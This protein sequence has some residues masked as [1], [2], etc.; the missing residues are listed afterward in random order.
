MTV[1]RHLLARAEPAP[2]TSEVPSAAPPRAVHRPWFRHVPT[3]A[4]GQRFDRYG[5]RFLFALALLVGALLRL[6]QLNRYGVNS[7]EAVYL[8]QAAALAQEPT[9]SQFFPLFRAHPLLFSF[10]VSLTIPFVGG[11]GLDLAGRLLA[12][13]FGLG[14]ILL[15]MLLGRTLFG[16]WVGAISALFLAL[17]PYHVIVSRQA[18]LDGPMAF[19]VT[20]TVLAF[21]R[22][23]ATRRTAWLVTTAIALGL[24]TLTKETAILFLGAIVVTLALHPT[25]SRE[26][27]PLLASAGVLLATIAVHPLATALA[28]GRGTERTAQYLVWQ[29]FRRPNHEWWFY[30]W[31]VLPSFGLLVVGL[32]LLG[33]WIVRRNW[34]WR[35]TLLVAWV[36]VPFAFFQVWPTKGYPYLVATTPVMAILAART[37]AR[38]FAFGAVRSGT[39]RRL[40]PP[41]RRAFGMVAV[42]AVAASLLLVSATQLRAAT[43][44]TF[45]AGSGGVPGGREAGQWIRTHTPQGAKLLTIGPSMANIVQ[46]YGHRK[47]YGLS[48]SPNPLHRNPS[49]EPVVNPDL[50]LRNGELQYVVW[51]AF[52]AARSPFFAEKLLTYARRYHG[53]VVHTEVIRTLDANGQP[54]DLP[55]IVIYEV[56]P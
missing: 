31:T 47:A 19:W 53:R 36:V 10:F 21:V 15:T 46:F 23:A 43:N 7:D 42:L 16:P 14:T 51:D 3:L 40:A 8:G 26:F 12:L 20:L 18:L 32:T 25:L 55:V 39:L 45:L 13:A 2:S 6:W 48:V 41:L 27:R 24:A 34:S 37:I 54:V 56:R 49:Y 28:G 22:Y 50:W 33:L 11:D 4:P 52:S 35:E 29:L 9:L 30:L 5:P 1:L 17:M 38:V 44:G